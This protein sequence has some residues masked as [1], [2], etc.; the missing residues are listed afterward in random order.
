IALPL[1]LDFFGLL[2]IKAFMTNV[3]RSLE[4]GDR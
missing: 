1:M 3:H 2:R 4:T